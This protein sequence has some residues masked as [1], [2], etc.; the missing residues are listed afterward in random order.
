MII[1]DTALAERQADNNP[2]RVGLV[3]AGYMGRG[4]A[5]QIVTA[6]PGMKLV[7]VAN[8]HL[9]DAHRAYTQAGVDQVQPV[10][11]LPQLEN[12]ISQNQYAITEDALL[13]ARCALIDVIIEAT[14]TIDFGAA[15]VLTA[16]DHHKHVVMMNAE[17][18]ATLGPILKVYANRA[19]VVLTNSDGDQ[20]GVI[21]NLF[22]YVQAIGCR[23]VLAGNMK[24]LHDPYRTPA[25]QR[26]YAERYKQ[27]PHM[28]TSF[29]DGT[30]ISMEM[31]VVANATGFRTGQ[32]GMYGPDCDHVDHAAGLF[33]KEEML[34]G[35]L[36][37][38]VVG[39]QPGGGVFIIGYNDNPIQQQY[40][41]YYKM[42]EGPFYVFYTPY[43]LCHLETPFTA[44]RAVLFGDAALTPL[45]GPVCDVVTAAKRNLKAGETIDGF[46]GFMSYGLLENS[47]VCLAQ[48]LLPLG[49][50]QGC[51]LRHDV[52][53]DCVLTYADVSVPPNRLSDR[54]RTE[55]TAHFA[56]PEPSPYA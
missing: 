26:S 32:R 50:A 21:M 34:N 16:V 44:A 54:L 20:P 6:V 55:Q 28:V 47:D 3:G 19:G 15:V 35:G 24:G 13:L 42:G 7:A 36:V 31:A 45:G 2:I 18:D 46:G 37:D 25:T 5:L 53:Q 17:L 11:T 29:A 41:N 1:I 22:R 56:Q 10:E 48:N 38:Y 12:A 52:P 30:K 27:K 51:Q 33:P 9:A 49:L 14:G 8:R 39:A 43:H 40:L 4:I 23:P